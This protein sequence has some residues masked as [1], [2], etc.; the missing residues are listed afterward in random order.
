MTVGLK[1][2]HTFSNYESMTSGDFWVI[3][4]SFCYLLVTLVDCRCD[5]DILVVETAM[6]EN[7]SQLTTQV[8]NL[9]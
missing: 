7:K 5:G 9:I 8:N 2:R 1:F 4:G 3:L 6:N